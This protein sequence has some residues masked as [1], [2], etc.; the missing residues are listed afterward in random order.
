MSSEPHT[1]SFTSP[2]QIT[3]GPV[4]TSL[5][6][7]LHSPSEAIQDLGPQCGL[8]TKDTSIPTLGCG[9]ITAI[10][11]AQHS[12]PLR[13][14]LSSTLTTVWCAGVS[15]HHSCLPHKVALQLSDTEGTAE[16]RDHSNAH[17]HPLGH[18]GP[19]PGFSLRCVQPVS[20]TDSVATQVTRPMAD[21]RAV[22]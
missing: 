8:H 20:I 17:H 21:T 2:W 9:T 15:G 3:E 18:A 1:S 22:A 13:D 10:R 12:T 4:A 7:V 14:G 16:V 11:Q 5:S 19:G 6:S